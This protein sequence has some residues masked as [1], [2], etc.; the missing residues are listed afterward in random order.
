LELIFFNAKLFLCAQFIEAPTLI[1]P[2]KQMNKDGARWNTVGIKF[3]K[4]MI[5]L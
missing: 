1:D 2:T 5:A 3:I 4:I